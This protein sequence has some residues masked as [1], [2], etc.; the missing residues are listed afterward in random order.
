MWFRTFIYCGEIFIKWLKAYFLNSINLLVPFNMYSCL[1]INVDNQGKT[2]WTLKNNN[3]KK[4]YNV[5]TTKEK[6]ACKKNAIF[7]LYTAA[8]CVYLFN[9]KGCNYTLGY[10]CTGVFVLFFC[11]THAKSRQGAIHRFWG[12][13]VVEEKKVGLT[14]GK[15]KKK[16]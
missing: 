6:I 1:V 14:E 7:I 2:S 3:K 5:R 10:R 4:V 11:V 16:L 15:K 9:C 8:S 12:L 13:F